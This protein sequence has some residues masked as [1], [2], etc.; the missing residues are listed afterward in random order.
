MRY[1]IINIWNHPSTNKKYLLDWQPRPC[2]ATTPEL[3]TDSQDVVKQTFKIQ[4]RLVPFNVARWS[5][6]LIPERKCKFGHHNQ[7]LTQHKELKPSNC[8]RTCNLFQNWSKM[9]QGSMVAI[10]NNGFDNLL[11]L[12]RDTCSSIYMLNIGTQNL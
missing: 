11:H 12:Q 1:F 7:W 2:R 9:N 5:C 8:C 10:S 4:L 3:L 6:A